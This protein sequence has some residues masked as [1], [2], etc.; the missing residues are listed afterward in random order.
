MAQHRINRLKQTPV[1]SE[2]VNVKGNESLIRSLG[3]IT[4]DG[5]RVKY[6][7]KLQ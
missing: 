1:L 2:V 5:L 7:Q 3:G 6:N 4:N